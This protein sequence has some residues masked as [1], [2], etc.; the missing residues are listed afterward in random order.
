MVRSY[1]CTLLY[2]LASCPGF[3]DTVHVVVCLAA[4]RLCNQSDFHPIKN[5]SSSYDPSSEK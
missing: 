2:Y 4:K 3:D 1:N 5:V